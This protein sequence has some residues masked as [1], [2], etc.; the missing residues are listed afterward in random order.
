MSQ[1][2]RVVGLLLLLWGLPQH[3]GALQIAG[4]T[5]PDRV[6][7][8]GMEEELV[9]NGA[10]IR[11]KFFFKI[12]IGALYL[13][14]RLDTAAAILD[15]NGPNRVLMHFLY[16]EVSA[17]K[18]TEGWI[19]GFEAN[20]D[21]TGLAALGPR[22]QQ[23]T[24]LFRDAVRGDRIWID[25]LP[26]TGTRVSINGREQGVVPGDDFNRALLRIWLGEAPVSGDLKRAMLGVE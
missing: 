25:H 6:R 2:A 12:Y 11:R 23:F 18:L 15:G 5:L 9:L 16:D 7:P 8:P 17:R 4:V 3:A 13:P 14:T 20:L 24:T 19:S 1:T 10:G 21:T 26:G 22:I